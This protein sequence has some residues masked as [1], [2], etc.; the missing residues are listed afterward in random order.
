[1]LLLF[2]ID[3]TLI[4][5]S[6]TV[7]PPLLEKVIAYLT[8]EGVVTGDPQHA[9][10]Q[11]K[12]LD[13]ASI[14]SQ[15]AI[16][17]FVELCD[18]S[19]THYKAALLEMYAPKELPE[20][21]HAVDGA[22]ELVSRLARHYTLGIVSK[23]KE[24]VQREKLRK[25]G[26]PV[27]LFEYIYIS[28]NAPKED[29]YKAILDHSGISPQKI[30]VVGDRIA[31]DLSPAKRLGMNTVH[32]KWGRGLGYTGIKTDVDY[33]ITTLEQLRSILEEPSKEGYPNV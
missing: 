6:G 17:E 4:D 23:G 13:S 27:D 7:I 29:A 33:T 22:V 14:S 10:T 31:R 32:M 16:H 5:T 30:F 21:V 24:S 8:K 1:M 26:I 20:H 11:L 18:G 2:D 3:D 12:T 15:D 28:E 9:F 25:A 19:D